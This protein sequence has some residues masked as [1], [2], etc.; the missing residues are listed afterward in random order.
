MIVVTDTSVIL[1]LCWLRQE[2]LL[3][4]I[5][6]EIVAPGLVQREFE[7]WAATDTR[8]RGLHFPDFILV[9]DPTRI[10]ADLLGNPHLDPG[11]VNAIALALERGIDHILID[12]TAGRAAATAHGLRVSGLLGL[13]IESKRRLLVP[14]IRPLLDRLDTEA[15]FWIAPKL[16]KHIL[17]LAGE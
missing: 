7:H 3:P 9:A 10:P 11:E 15:R 2:N 17:E 4:V 6:T 5:H 13:L 12:E 8:F 16:R 14:A 1:N